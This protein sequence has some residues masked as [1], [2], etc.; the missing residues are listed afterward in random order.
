[1]KFLIADDS[2]LSRNKLSQMI[3]DL[4]YEVLDTAV[5][6]QEAVEKFIKLNPTYIT[7]DLEMPVKRG[8]KAA[9]E[10]LELNPDVNIILVTSIVDK[11]ELLTAI[12][13]G[14]K[15]VIQKPVT[16]EKLSQTIDELKIWGWTY[17][18]RRD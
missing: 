12:K 14:V 5:N 1:M 11:K 7:M 8:D 3:I 2:K 4:G 16:I 6:G 15:K 18:Y 10:I 13:F 17:E 9:K